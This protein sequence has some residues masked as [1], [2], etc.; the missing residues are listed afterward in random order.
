MDLGAD[1]QKLIEKMPFIADVASAKLWGNILSNI[2]VTGS[3]NNIVYAVVDENVIPTANDASLGGLS[4][5]M[6]D[7]G[8]VDVAILFRQRGNN[9]VKVSFR[10]TPRVNVG[11]I[12][13]TLDGGGHNNA[14][15]CIITGKSLDDTINLVISAVKD[16]VERPSFKA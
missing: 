3:R 5:F 13:L 14:S 2:K 10:S 7:I 8:G 16:S 6:R 4:A 1:R 9:E 15:S 11:R 12:A